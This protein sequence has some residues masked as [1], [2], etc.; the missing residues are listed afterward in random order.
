MYV[1]QNKSSN[2]IAKFFKCDSSTILRQLKRWNAPI[3][4]K[5]YN[6]KYD[7]ECDFFKNID[8]EEKAYFLGLLLA[9]GHIS[10]NDIIMLTL[11]DKDVIEKYQHAIKTNTPIKIDR[12]GNYQLNIGC[13][14]MAEDLR[15]IGLHN[16]K[17]YSLDFN[18]VLSY[19]PEKLE[20]HFVRG[21]FDGD[22]SIKIYKYDYVK[23]P[24][25][26]FGYTG[27]KE[28]VDYIKS[29]FDIH[30]KT[31][32]ESDITYT[33]VSSCKETINHIYKILYNN[34]TIYMDRKYSTFKQII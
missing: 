14:E 34:A 15:R 9:D 23:N 4:R 13:K 2:S 19:V 3:R 5:R 18:K 27:L 17:S 20:N 16:R 31:V 12:Y 22:G 11:H 1:N 28:V 32:K 7:L 29:Y 21:M 10:K 8:T 6:A 24:Q 26:H 30:T 25:Y 33:C